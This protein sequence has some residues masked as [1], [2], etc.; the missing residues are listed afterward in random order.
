MTRERRAPEAAQWQSDNCPKWS[1]RNVFG[2]QI[3]TGTVDDEDWRALPLMKRGPQ[4][5]PEASASTKSDLNARV[6]C[7]AAASS[8]SR[9]CARSWRPLHLTPWKGVKR[10]G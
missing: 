2:T 1:A 5:T 9:P 3:K 4:A 10:S 8:R 7:F 6:H